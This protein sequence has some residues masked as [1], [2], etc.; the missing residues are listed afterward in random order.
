VIDSGNDQEITH[1]NEA[2]RLH[3]IYVAT[4]CCSPHVWRNRGAFASR[5]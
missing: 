5:L 1:Q 3:A 4:R 2:K